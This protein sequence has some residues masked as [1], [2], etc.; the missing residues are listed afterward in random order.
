M[1][2]TITTAYAAA[3]GLLYVPLSFA[4]I[5]SRRRSGVSLGDG[6]QQ[7]LQRRVRAHANFAEYV[8]IVLILL[9]LAEL[10]GAAPW[11]LHLSG[12][13]LLL[14]RC[15]HAATFLFTQRFMP[16]RVGGMVM[17]FFSLISAAIACAIAAMRT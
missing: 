5:R 13:S 9:L 10:G 14:G 17:T 6:G 8:P 15:L 3:L 16:G 12:A 7:E 4:V 1:T 11:R 2:P